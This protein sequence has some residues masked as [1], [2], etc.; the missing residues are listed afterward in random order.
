MST[1]KTR[2]ARRTSDARRPDISGD[3]SRAAATCLAFTQQLPAHTPIS[4]A[5]SVDAV[6][7]HLAANPAPDGE[8]T[9][10]A[11]AATNRRNVIDAL[12]GL[13]AKTGDRELSA[14]ART[15][16]E[17]AWD[18]GAEPSTPE[19]RSPAAAVER[20]TRTG[21]NA[22]VLLE[23]VIRHEA[24]RHLGLV[25]HQSNKLS[26]SY[27]G[28][29]PEDLFGW[30]WTGLVVALRRYDPASSAFSTYA[31]T[32]IVGHIQDGVRTESP[33]P[34]RLSTFKR[35][36]ESTTVI[37]GAALGRLPAS[38]EVAEAL[39]EA[40]LTSQ[41]GRRP[42]LEEIAARV[43][44][45]LSQMAL[46]P[47]LVSPAS[48]DEMDSNEDGSPR[49]TLSGGDDPA[50]AAVASLNSERLLDALDGLDALD[51]SVISLV[52]INGVTAAE[53]AAQLGITVREVR[54]RREHGFTQLQVTLADLAP[55]YATSVRR[56]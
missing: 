3:L 5:D 41:L 6:A 51:R 33:I 49:F 50:E 43:D 16:L 25:H 11:S 52:D 46:L 18:N 28:Y 29:S 45:E 17:H 56:A 21:I 39:A 24:G 36:V 8:N 15:A 1:T 27:G 34:K 37:L 14:D 19:D 30:A 32:R 2:P 54:A 53:A 55:A 35:K 9:P 48:I 12:A 23:G 31:V 47:R 7:A 22:G 10:S 42:S 44:A 26:G 38:A 4:V 20:L 13:L 40:H